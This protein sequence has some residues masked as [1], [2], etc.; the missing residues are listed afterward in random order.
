M[1]ERASVVFPFGFHISAAG[2]FSRREF[3]KHDGFL[4]DLNAGK[5]LV[6]CLLDA[7]RASVAAICT[8]RILRVSGSIGHPQVCESVV[9]SD[10]VDMV[11]FACWPR[12]RHIQPSQAVSSVFLPINADDHVPIAVSC[13]TRIIQRNSIC[14]SHLA[15]KYTGIRVVIQQLTK[16]FCAW[17]AG[18]VAS[19]SFAKVRYSHVARVP[20]LKDQSRGW[21]RS[22]KMHPSNQGKRIGSTVKAYSFG[23]IGQLLTGNNRLWSFW[24]VFQPRKSS[25]QSVVIDNLAQPVD[26]NVKFFHGDHPV[27]KWFAHYITSTV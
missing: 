5:P 23:C 22:I 11:D 12:A 8:G 17:L 27:C 13:G 25:S 10:S 7:F 16:S 6:T 1:S 21:R 4:I 14:R 15:G 2:L 9:I 19:S 18:G 26:C 3:A 24:T 20:V